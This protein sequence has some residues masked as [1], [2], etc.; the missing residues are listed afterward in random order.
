[1]CPF[2]DVVLERSSTLLAAFAQLSLQADRPCLSCL[3]EGDSDDLLSVGALLCWWLCV[4]F[5][6]MPLAAVL[7][8]ACLVVLFL[9][10]FR[11]KDVYM[12]T[13]DRSCS[14]VLKV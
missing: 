1:M 10:H 5:N 8:H 7:G 4:C 13:V 14:L 9:A 6:G 2:L 3:P 11:G 12:S